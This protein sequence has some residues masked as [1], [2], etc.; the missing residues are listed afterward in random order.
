MNTALEKNLRL[1]RLH[2]LV[3]HTTPWVVVMA[4]F[5]NQNFGVSGVLSLG[6]VAYF[7]VVAFEVPSGWSSDRFGRVIT[8]R[9]VGLAWVGAMVCFL[10]GQDSFLLVA[11]GQTL[12]G[13]G[14]AAISGTDVTFHYD[15]LEALGREA[16]YADRQA[17]VNST[18]RFVGAAGLIVGGLLGLI[19]LRLP[20]V[21][22]LVFATVQF[23]VTLGF[24]E[25]PKHS[26]ADPLIRQ[27]GLCAR[28]LR[29]IPMAWIFGYGIAMVVLEHVAHTLL[30]PWMTEVLGETADDVGAT[31]IFVGVTM[32]VIAMI[33]ALAARSSATLARRFGLRTTLVALGALSAVIVTGMAVWQHVVVIALVIFRSAHGAAAPILISAAVAPVVAQQHR[34]TFL[35][36]NSLVGRAFYGSLLLVLSGSVEDNVPRALTQFSILSW[37]L[38]LLTAAT[39]IR[40]HQR[41]GEAS[42]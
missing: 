8:L 35:S 9:F 24:T 21:A 4:L 31:P 32:A 42:I 37:I 20:F 36:L 7:A 39:A 13:A 30:Q 26:T 28:Y 15:T 5:I 3:L 12:I 2:E 10:L 25:P 34:A 19:D 16:E 11:L 27:L 14:Y 1:I 38:V 17:W 6:S 29:S 33:A 41:Y 23:A 22:S 18:G 40:V